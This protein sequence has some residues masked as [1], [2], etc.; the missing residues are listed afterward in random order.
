MSNKEIKKLPKTKIVATLGP[1]TESE[2]GIKNLIEAGLSVARLNCSHGDWDTRVERLKKVR[3][4]ALELNRPVGILVDLQGPKIRTGTLPEEGVKIE[5]GENIILTT[6]KTDSDY[7][8]DA[9]IKK[10]FVRNYPE[11]TKDVE[12]SQ[13]ILIDDGVIR[14]EAT[15]VRETEVEAKVIF[16][17]TVKSNKG[18]NLPESDQKNLASI[19]DKDREDIIEAVKNSAEFIALS[20]VKTAADIIELKQLINECN[21]DE[22]PIKVI[23]KIEKPQA[24][25]KLDEILDVV[26]G[27]MVARGDLGV[28]LEPQKVPMIQKEII[29]KANYKKKFVIT[30]TQMMDSMVSKPFPTRA[31]VSDVAN[32]I[33]DG[34]DAVMLSN[35]TAM[36]SYPT[37]TVSQMAKIALEVETNGEIKVDKR[38]LKSLDLNDVDN[39]NHLA[40]AQSVENFSKLKHI[41]KILVFTCSGKSATMISKLRPEAKVIAATTYEHTYNYLSI[42]WGVIPIYFDEVQQTTETIYNLERYLVAQGI[43]EEGETVVVTGG[44]PIAARGPS[45]FVKLHK[46]DGSIKELKQMSKELSDKKL[47]PTI[48]KPD[49]VT[50]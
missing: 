12:A 36:G 42:V 31:E 34:T 18:V 10:I 1:A 5:N 49:A 2:E 15:K 6:V 30:A 38:D 23:A 22:L 11:L 43:V 14:L 25:E 4:A 37:E 33:L 26:D 19:T 28:E 21:V 46:C 16:G 48:K 32:A 8:N 7:R 44:L 13:A 27:V 39:I 9:P 50:A 24:V 3:A 17:G 41:D 29:S 35:E 45:N 40:I 20:F 47:G